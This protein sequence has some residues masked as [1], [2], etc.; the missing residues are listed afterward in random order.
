MIDWLNEHIGSDVATYVGTLLAILGLFYGCAKVVKKKQSQT[1]K[2]GTGI[3][4]GGNITINT[5]SDKD[6]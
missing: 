5:N 2:G 6:K 3:Q 1:V 4:V